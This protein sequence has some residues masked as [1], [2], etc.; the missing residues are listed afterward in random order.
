M[1]LVSVLACSSMRHARQACPHD[2]TIMKRS[3]TQMHTRTHAHMR[4]C[5]HTHTYALTSSI[6]FLA[7][8]SIRYTR[9]AFPH[10]GTLTKQMS[11][12]CSHAR[13][14]TRTHAHTRTHTYL[15]RRSASWHASQ[16]DTP[17]KLP[18]MMA[19]ASRPAAACHA[20]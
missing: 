6:S 17:G 9:Q 19:H 18:Q 14:H 13:M 4:T 16:S 11:H 15:R 10:Q 2:G 12:T 8:S 3:Q 20:G 7:R 5:T 1:P